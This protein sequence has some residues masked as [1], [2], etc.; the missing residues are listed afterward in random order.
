MNKIWERV[1][2]SRSTNRPTA[3]DYISN[4][5]TNIVEIK[6]DQVNFD[7]PSV[8]CCMAK[9]NNQSV[10]V[11]AHEKGKNIEAKVNHNFG[12]ANPSGYRKALRAG[13]LAQKFN[14]PIIFLPDTPGA[15]PGELSEIEGQGYIISECIKYFM[16]VDV[17]TIS[18]LIGEGGSGGAIAFAVANYV[19]MLENAT[20]SILSPEGFASILWKDASKA[21]E[22]AQ[23]LKPDADS[24]FEQKII[25]Q[26]INEHQDDFIKTIEEIKQ[27]I[28]IQ[29]KSQFELSK[30]QLINQKHNR[31]LN[32]SK[33]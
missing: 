4:I 29:L 12:M 13:K 2:T 33:I 24:L 25:D 16:S 11:I 22:A 31:Y 17:P 1:Q 28:S 10:V 9:F 19:A 23:L 5:F 21:P 6:G 27:M 26:I 3:V 14:F 8:I 32:L 18:I 20:Y 30:E 15:Y 7:D